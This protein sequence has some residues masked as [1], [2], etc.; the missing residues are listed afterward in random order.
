MSATTSQ[1]LFLHGGPTF[2]TMNASSSG[3]QIMQLEI[4][5]EVLEQLLDSARHGKAPSIHFGDH[6]VRIGWQILK[7]TGTC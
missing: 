4:S 5:D 1:E 3:P 6:P 7:V 2:D